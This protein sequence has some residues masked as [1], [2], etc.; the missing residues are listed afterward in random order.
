MVVAVRSASGQ[1]A[2]GADRLLTEYAHLVRGKSLALVTNHSGVLADGTH[3]ADALFRHKDVKLKALFGMEHDIRSNDYSL[4][5][6][7][8]RV[9]DQA[10]GLPK[11]NLYGEHHKP[12]AESLAG[13]DVI[14]FDI[15]EV[16]ARFY[17]HINILGFVMEA[18]AEQGISVVVL[19]RPNPIT[20]RKVDG[21]VTATDAL[22]RFGSYAR[23][24]VVHGMT[25]A[26]L[27]RMYNGE[28]ML[29]GSMAAKLDVV[30]MRGWT[31]DMWLD[32]TG[33]RWQKP[34]PNLL[35][36]ESLLAYVGTCLFEAVNVS[37]G[38]GTDNPFEIIGASWLDNGR[39]VEMLRG[40]S[41]RGV[42]FEAVEFTPVQKAF[43]GR[44]PKLAGELLRGIRLRVTDRD[45]FEPYRTGVAMLWAVN[46]LHGD[47]LVW[48]DAVLDR[49]VATPQL[50]SML[51]AG[52][53]PA[54]IFAAWRPE[55]DAF[56]AMSAKYLL[57]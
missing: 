2:V 44:P 28:R 56:R 14:V 41:L 29:R 26:E 50:K 5:R 13:V 31:R 52:N 30:P 8:E 19:D 22:Y 40:L 37:E 55:V 21:F 42:T 25:M 10:T 34:S 53:T 20:G 18:A 51:L 27:A 38:R 24:P 23:V 17:E 32:Q 33:Q 16:G 48:N 43:H 3:L 15:Q 7:P 6:D 57:Y 4:P 11:Y 35:T 54:E 1:V 47:R 49:L 45:A 9:I 12:T 39:A 36:L 46:R